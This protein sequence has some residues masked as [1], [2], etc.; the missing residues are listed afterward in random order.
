[1]LR[2]LNKWR[3]TNIFIDLQH[4]MDCS[5]CGCVS[6]NA[7]I[8][9]IGKASQPQSWKDSMTENGAEQAQ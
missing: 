6:K 1:M 5:A 7:L 9:I 4:G 2:D 3:K 8:S